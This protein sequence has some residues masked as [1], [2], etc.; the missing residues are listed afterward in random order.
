MLWF[1]SHLVDLYMAF[2]TLNKAS[3]LFKCAN[4]V[5]LCE[6]YIFGCDGAL[7]TRYL[8]GRGYFF[9]FVFIDRESAIVLLKELMWAKLCLNFKKIMESQTCLRLRTRVSLNLEAIS[10]AAKDV[11]DLT[12]SC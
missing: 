12:S 4:D 8:R 6:L 1:C 7:C 2:I 10:E 5:S 3:T 9:L 11:I